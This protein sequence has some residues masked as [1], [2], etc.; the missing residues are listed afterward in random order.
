MEKGSL[1]MNRAYRSTREPP[2]HAA[3]LHQIWPQAVMPALKS[4]HKATWG[5]IT[6]MW[7][8]TAQYGGDWQH[9]T[10]ALRQNGMLFTGYF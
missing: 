5:D 3:D 7:P 4:G 8:A 1:D 9:E 10:E 6:Q 2:I